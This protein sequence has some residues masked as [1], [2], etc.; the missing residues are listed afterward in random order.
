MGK[1][2]Y[3]YIYICSNVYVIINFLVSPTAFAWLEC[4]EGIKDCEEFLRGFDIVGRGGKAFGAD[5]KFVR[6]SL[7]CR[8]EDFNGIIERLLEI[9]GIRNGN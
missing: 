1:R 8:D 2:I 5:P 9:K 6:V 3:I 4:K 7:L